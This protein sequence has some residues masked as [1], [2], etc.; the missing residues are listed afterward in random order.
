MSGPYDRWPT[1]SGFDKFYGFIGGETNQ[2]APAI[3]DGV[4]ARRAAAGSR[5]TTSPPT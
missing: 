3:Y 4:V 2:W 1:R 5:I